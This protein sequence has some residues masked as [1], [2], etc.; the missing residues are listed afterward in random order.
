[1]F[2]K[3]AAVVMCS[4]GQIIFTQ[5]LYVEAIITTTSECDYKWRSDL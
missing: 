2:I 4:N 3:T 1:M 5:N